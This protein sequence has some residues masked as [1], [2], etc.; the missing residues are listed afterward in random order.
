M[1]VA[2]VAIDNGHGKNMLE[3]KF[4]MIQLE[5]GILTILQLSI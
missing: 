3:K 2:Y 5:N 1:T 4:L